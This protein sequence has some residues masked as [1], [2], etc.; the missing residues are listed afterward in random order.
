[1]D[2][3]FLK[4]NVI[5]LTFLLLTL[6]GQAMSDDWVYS[7]KKGDTLWSLASGYL[8]D[9]SY[10]K[11]I[12]RLNNISDPLDLPVGSK[13]KIP[14]EWLKPISVPVYADAIE[15][16]IEL[17]KKTGGSSTLKKGDVLEVGDRVLTN[18][19]S[20]VLL[21]FKD[22]TSVIVE[23]NSDLEI[24]TLIQ[25]KDNAQS[26]IQ[27]HLKKGRV[28]T[29]VDSS[30][31][32]KT[33]FIIRTPVSMTSVRGTRYRV[34]AMPEDD[35]SHT[36]VLEGVVDVSNVGETQKILKDYGTVV[37]K[38]Q[39]PM[40]PIKLLD[41]PSVTDIPKVFG[42]F[43]AHFTLP[44]LDA[45]QKYR[46]QI[47]KNEGF[48]SILFNET[49]LSSVIQLPELPDATYQARIRQIDQYGLEGKNAYFSIVFNTEPKAPTLLE[50]KSEAGFVDNKLDFSWEKGKAGNTYLFQLSSTKDFSQLLV[51][52]NN[53]SSS[54]VAW[55]KEL[56]DGKYYWRVATIDQDGQGPFSSVRVVHKKLP[57]PKVV[58]VKMIKGELSVNFDS[59]PSK[60][61]R[62]Q[63]QVAKTKQFT[64]LVLDKTFETSILKSPA[65]KGG[66]YYVRVRA[67][68]KNGQVSPFSNPQSINVPQEKNSWLWIIPFLVVLVFI[69]I[70]FR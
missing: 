2:N 22:D 56:E 35:V 59:A 41:P 33:E 8:I 29:N 55:N 16:I 5:L 7:V 31:K 62:Y 34:S 46:L 12:Q 3:R 1:M 65:L 45:K 61:L 66:Q 44:D 43:P 68:E 14:T 70:K 10:L 38:G 23:E 39:S 53:I 36:E 64:S 60:G 24:E 20:S 17:I 11:K 49:F 32:Y 51:N 63:F 13:I 25:P 54:H 18:K 58:A 30:K 6:S 15:G 69:A 28:E 47:S 40:P 19:N 50:P 67:V 26:K 42:V 52:K 57:A 9:A 21:K 4:L 27:L 48:Q 37:L